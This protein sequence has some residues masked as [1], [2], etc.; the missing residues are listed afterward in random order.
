MPRVLAAADRQAANTVLARWIKTLG[1]VP[2]CHPCARVNVERRRL[3][4]D[5]GWIDDAHR[6]GRSLSSKLRDIRANRVAG[7]QYYVASTPGVANPIFWHEP[8]YPNIRFPDSGF[9]LL[10]LFRFWNVVAYWYPYR[11]EI[12]EN[13]DKVLTE[14]VPRLALAHTRTVYELAL[15]RFIAEVHD[16]HANLWS[17]LEVRP[18]VGACRIPVQLQFVRRRPVVTKR[19]TRAAPN[20]SRLERSDVLTRLGGI[21]VGRLV[22]KCSPYY[23]DS[24]EAARLRDIAAQ[25]TRGTCGSV[26]VCI[27]RAG[28]QLSL[29]VERIKVP[30]RVLASSRWGVLPGP[31]VQLLSPQVAYLKLSSAKAD[32]AT[33]YIRQAQGTEGL[34]IDLRDYPSQSMVFALGSHLVQRPTP[35]VR[36][37]YA[38]FADRGAFVWGN[39]TSISPAAPHYP[40]K[41]V[42]LVNQ[43]T[44]SDAE[45]TAMAFRAAPNALV[46]GSTTAGAD[47]NVSRVPLPGGLVS[48]ISGLGIYYPDRRQRS[49]SAS[50]RT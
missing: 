43:L 1:P 25:M 39:T 35:F 13:W 49:A 36:F 10:V 21:P 40:G 34:I 16:S 48:L 29:R 6:L 20:P 44:Q 42:I 2:R 46:V 7:P 19:L 4:P 27:R 26:P 24:N 50:F 32:E 23:G 28:R 41:V 37:R 3:R 31:A 14:F 9:Q 47:G 30:R 33:E 38:D 8:R 45:Y 17:A 5:L 18:P 11:N 12:G 22:R 15:M